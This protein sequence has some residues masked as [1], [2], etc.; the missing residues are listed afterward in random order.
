MTVSSLLKY[1]CACNFEIVEFKLITVPIYIEHY[2]HHRQM[3]IV[4][5]N[6]LVKIK[7]V[8]VSVE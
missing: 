4:M 1:F 8:N 7:T 2:Y 6:K 3:Q 5:K